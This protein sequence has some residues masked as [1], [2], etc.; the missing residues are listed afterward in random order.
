MSSVGKTY[1]QKLSTCTL[2][3]H[4]YG[5]KQQCHSGTEKEFAI[6]TH[7]ILDLSAGD[8]W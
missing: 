1:D 3:S 5:L 4:L 7:L 6:Y 8:R 2:Y